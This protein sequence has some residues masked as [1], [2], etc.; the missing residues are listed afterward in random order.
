MLRLY[1]TFFRLNS[2]SRDEIEIAQKWLKSFTVSQ[3]PP[4]VFELSYSRSSGPGGQKVN[5]TSSKATLSMEAEQWLNPKYCYWIPLAIRHQIGT[6]KIRYETKNGGV[7]IQSDA[8][9]NR[10]VNAAE[11]YRKLLTEIREK[12]VFEGETSEEDLKRWDGIKEERAEVRLYK[13]K[14]QSEKK[15][16]RGNVGW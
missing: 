10:D 2:T 16:L 11:C 14:K 6:N 8:N 4:N 5:K 1:R 12:V 3:I 15:K 13:K 9:R 7:V